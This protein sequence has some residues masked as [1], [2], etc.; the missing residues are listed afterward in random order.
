[1]LCFLLVVPCL[2]AA[3][4]HG[5]ASRCLQWPASSNFPVG[6]QVASLQVASLCPL[7]RQQ[8][9]ED[10]QEGGG[11]RTS[12]QRGM[13]AVGHCCKPACHVCELDLLSSWL[14]RV[15]CLCAP[16]QVCGAGGMEHTGA[17]ERHWGTAGPQVRLKGYVRC[18]AAQLLLHLAGSAEGSVKLLLPGLQSL[19]AAST[20]WAGAWP[21]PSGSWEQSGSSGATVRTGVGACIC[22]WGVP[23][24]ASA[25]LGAPIP[26]WPAKR[27][28]LT[29][30]KRYILLAEGMYS[31][32]FYCRQGE[33]GCVCERECSCGLSH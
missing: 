8:A 15:C 24:G 2:A 3:I 25:C 22:W 19:C 10:E 20:G 4:M 9:S 16:A 31:E 12:P 18:T 26:A 1:M 11:A 21:F 29:S 33:G 13:A 28:G 6:L 27:I 5:R 17:E 30:R 14:R 32:E 7:H 23:R